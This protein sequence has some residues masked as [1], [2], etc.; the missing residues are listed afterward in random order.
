MEIYARCLFLHD[1]KKRISIG[2]RPKLGMTE[3]CD[4]DEL[5]SIMIDEAKGMPNMVK[6]VIR[7]VNNKERTFYYNGTLFCRAMLEN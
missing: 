2:E 5:D 3:Y 6:V 1:I 7:D 4:I